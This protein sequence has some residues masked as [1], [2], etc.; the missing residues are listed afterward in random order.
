ML[1]KRKNSQYWWYKFT[2]P[3]GNTIR[4]SAKTTDKRK[5]RELADKHKAQSWDQAKLGHRPEYLWEDAVV[6]W[7]DESQK[8]SLEDDLVMFRYL[9]RFFS[10]MKL[11]DITHYLLIML[12]EAR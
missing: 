11:V 8:R 2:D 4:K 12:I 1:F 5:A 6:K 3:N 10:G 9:D 7:V